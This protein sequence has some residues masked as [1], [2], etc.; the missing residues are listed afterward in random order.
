MK[1]EI[2]TRMFRGAQKAASRRPICTQ[3]GAL[4]RAPNGKLD[5]KAVK[6]VALDAVGQDAA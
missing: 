6:A 5:Y 4:G 2:E 1:Q 3:R